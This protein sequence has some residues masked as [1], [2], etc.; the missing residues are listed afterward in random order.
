MKRSVFAAA[1][2]AALWACGEPSRPSCFVAPVKE[3]ARYVEL[4]PWFGKAFAFMQRDDLAQL[5]PGRYE[6]DGSN[7]WANVI[8]CDLKPFAATNVYEFHRAYIDLHVPILETET[9]GSLRTPET[10]FGTFNEK[11]D[12]AL[13]QAEGSALTV[14]PGEFAAFFPPVGAHAPGLTIATPCHQQKVVIK[15]RAVSPPGPSDNLTWIDGVDIPQ[16]GRAFA[17][18]QSPY[19]R[20]GEKHLSKIAPVNGGVAGHAFES[21][22]IC[23]RFVTDA[24]ELTFRWSLSRPQLEFPHMAAT[25]VSGIDIY[26]FTPDKGWRFVNWRF[27]EPRNYPDKQ[28][29]NI[30]TIK[31]TPGRPCWVYLPLYNGIADF[32]IGVARGKTVN[33]LPVRA[34]GVT[35]PVVFY[36]SSITQGACASRPGMAFTAIAGRQGDFPVVNLGFSGSAHMEPEVCDMLADI[37]ASCFVLDTLGNVLQV[38]GE[39]ESR[40]EAFVRRLHAAKPSVPIVLCA[41][42][43][44][45]FGR[46][47]TGV[48]NAHAIYEK[49][50]QEDPCAWGRLYWISE[51]DL[52]E[53]DGEHTV[54]GCHPND[55]GMIQMGKAHAKAVR[56]A[57]GL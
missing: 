36:G 18:T 56:A 50:K 13:F 11:D 39:L 54:D 45:D 22:G 23:Y 35:K 33:P 34:S 4:N 2:L 14:K 30:Y 53:D 55:W 17:D 24:D 15:V 12:Y 31:W 20:I 19:G 28:T 29:G 43:G 8:A 49:L 41:P 51:D 7:C 9:I 32:A 10:G 26:E 6:I 37:D 25:G 47:S 27:V 5:Q 57:L 3:A 21:A 52:C 38:P 44:G 1:I 42:G 48:A 46:P 40:Y 16:E